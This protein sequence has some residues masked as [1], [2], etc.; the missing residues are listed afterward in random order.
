MGDAKTLTDA[1][2][3]D[4]KF[5][6]LVGSLTGVAGGFS[7]ITGAMGIL[8]GKSKDVEQA[9]AKVNQAMALASGVQ[10]LGESIDSFKQLGAVIKNTTIF[11]RIATAAQWLWNA[12]LNANPIGAVVVA[13]TA[14][15]A[16]GYLMIKMF[17]S[18]TESVEASEE[19][20][21]KNTKA[22]E[23]ETEKLEENRKKKE[24]LQDYEL[25]LMKARG[26]SDEAIAKRAIVLAKENEQEAWKEYH[27]KRSTLE[28]AKNTIAT[29]ES[30]QAKIDDQMAN[31][32]W[33]S[34]EW[35]LLQQKKDI[36]KQDVKLA[37]ERLNSLVISYND[38]VKVVKE[39]QNKTLLAQENFNIV[40]AQNQTNADKEAAENQKK[41]DD[42]KLAKQENYER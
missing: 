38:S 35:G 16:A 36:N 20:I 26:K 39:A 15:I 11:Q 17:K 27:L 9:I 6:S 23:K 3:P 32:T 37:K 8:G 33:M 21:K 31:V 34:T 2:N 5:K 28:M 40:I 22:V 14:L 4:A 29:Y 1:F 18:S 7:A 13:I 10:A 19:A 24:Q 25:R 41:I 42:A 30:T 12:A